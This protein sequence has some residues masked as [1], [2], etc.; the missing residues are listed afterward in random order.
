MRRFL[1]RVSAS[2]AIAAT[3][4][5]AFGAPAVAQEAD[6]DVK[7]A[8]TPYLWAAALDGETSQF[9]LPDT[10]FYASFGDIWENLD[11]SLM[12][13]IDARYD[14]F[15][16]MGDIIYVNLGHE[17]RTNY[18]V[19]A[20]KVDLDIK[21]TRG[22]GLAGYDLLEQE[23]AWLDLLAGFEVW[24][25]STKISLK[26]GTLAG[27]SFK[28]S[29]TWVDFFGGARAGYQFDRNWSV[30]GWG[31]MGAGGSDFA[32]DVM[33]GGG[34]TFND[35]FS[36]LAGYRALGVTY[37][38]GNFEYDATQYGPFFGARFVF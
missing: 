30:Y 38:S 14:R 5:I 28:D 36:L 2:I 7:V 35:W 21:Q 22:V 9:G 12:A 10:D 32:W 26:G 23:A 19:L 29:A 24:S 27:R 15:V 6:D 31:L 25:V 20:N 16:V 17:S 1:T 11:F 33:A 18:G 3:T 37:S 34:Y 8:V 13:N 4:V